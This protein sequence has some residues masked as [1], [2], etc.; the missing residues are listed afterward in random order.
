MKRI[1]SLVL[2]MS[3]LAAMAFAREDYAKFIFKKSP[4][5]QSYFQRFLAMFQQQPFDGSYALIIA[6]GDY[7]NLKPLQAPN[8][9]AEKLK[10]VL[11]N[12]GDYDEVVVLRDADASFDNIRYFMQTYFPGK[13]KQNGRYRFLFYFSGHGQ[14][15][16]GYGENSIGY[17]LLKGATGELNDS[18]TIDMQQIQLW[19]DRFRY[20][21]HILFLLDCC[22]SGLAGV[23]VKEGDYNADVNPLDLAQENGR[24]MITAGQA[25]QTSVAD[26]R[27]WG[28]SLFTDVVLAGMNGKADNN[29]DGV[30]TTYELFGYTQAAVRNEAKKVGQKQSP[31]L[32][33]FGV[34]YKDTGQYFFVYKDPNPPQTVAV[35]PQADVEQKDANTPT[36]KPTPR[37][38]LEG[39]PTPEMTLPSSEGPGVG[40]CWENETP[41]ATCTEEITGMEFVYVP[42]GEFWMGCGEKKQGCY[43]NEKPRHQVRVNGFWIGKYEVTQAQWEAVIENNPS[44]FKGADRP[45]ETVSWN[46]AQEFLQTLNAA[47]SSVETHGRA[48]LQFRLPSESEWEY[49]ARAGTQTAYAFGDDPE[50][51]GDYAWYEG[52]SDSQ[53]HPVG[54]KKPNGFGLYDMHGNVWEWVADT[55]HENYNGA[56]E[57]GI[58]WGDLGDKKTKVL[59]GGSVILYPSDCRC[60]VRSRDNPDSRHYRYGFRVVVGVA[61]T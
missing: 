48:S 30:V 61:W 34:E 16:I 42:D 44:N 1:G 25:N 50:K 3:L 53:T 33:N 52:N 55:Y 28:G 39:K 46:D 9:D 59:R 14:E 43:D 57:N 47:A 5:T 45:V 11:L 37:P 31:V 4:D 7:D 23:E 2:I 36:P 20:A 60:A 18:E 10:K 38:S 58:F 13:M 19:A 26:L 29:H 12:T 41:G 27:R 54:Q 21:S 32:H 8:K 22:F 49:A 35:T 15:Q 56:P 6:V 51:L 40:S 24:F 17:L